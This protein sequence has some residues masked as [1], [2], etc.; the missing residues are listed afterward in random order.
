MVVGVP[1]VT[2]IGH[3]RVMGIM[4]I[5]FAVVLAGVSLLVGCASNP[6]SAADNAAGNGATQALTEVVDSDRDSI[7]DAQDKCDDTSSR[8]IVDPNGCELVTGPVPGLNFESNETDLEDSAEVILRRYVEAMNRYPDIVVQVE[9]HTDNRG[10]AG[11]NLEL[12]KER[13]LSVVQFM[14]DEGISPSRIKPV[15][16][17][18]SRPRAANATAEG[19]EQ[20]RRIEIKVVEGL[21]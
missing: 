11:E 4:K 20:N 21:L 7:P 16:Y 1:H 19:R 6:P 13:V 17:G 15:G 8:V 9:G 10:P 18:E 3:I 12:S 14:V 2:T 5:E